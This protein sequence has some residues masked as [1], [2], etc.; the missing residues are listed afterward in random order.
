V[1]RSQRGCRYVPAGLYEPGL[2]TSPEAGLAEDTRVDGFLQSDFQFVVLS[3]CRGG[4]ARVG[5]TKL[6]ICSRG[7]PESE[8]PMHAR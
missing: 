4:V 7:M 5:S 8:S 3:Y 1:R 2:K 6:V